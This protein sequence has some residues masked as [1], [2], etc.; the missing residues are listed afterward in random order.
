MCRLVAYAGPPLPLEP[1]VFHGEHSLFRQ[2]W[3]P[4]EL[5]SGSVNVDGYGIAW[6]AG[7]GSQARIARAEPIWYDEDLRDL[8]RTVRSPVAQAALRNATPGLPVDRSAVLPLVRENWAFTLNGAIPAFRERHMRALRGPLSDARYASLTGVGDAE[9]LFLRVLQNMHQGHGPH[10]AMQDAVAAVEARLDDGE[11]AAL[12][13]ILSS[14]RGVF[15]AHRSLG[16]GPCNSLY[17]ASDPAWAPGGA[18]V[19]S[20]RLDETTEWIPVPPQSAWTLFPD[21]RSAQV[22]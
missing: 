16:G 19:A 9:T 14:E 17:R 2:S 22:G 4:Q 21:G 13:L 8:L 12:T 18:V 10:E 7:D 3:A 15:V 20:E 11:V 5:L 6:S 1:L